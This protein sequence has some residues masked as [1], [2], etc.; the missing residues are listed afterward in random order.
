MIYVDL[1]STIQH[2]CLQYLA[3]H[4][5][6]CFFA[7]L[8]QQGINTLPDLIIFLF[9]CWAGGGFFSFVGRLAMP[10]GCLRASSNP[11]LCLEL[12]VHLDW[13]F[14]SLFG[15]PTL[16]VRTNEHCPHHGVYRIKELNIR[17]NKAEVKI[18]K[19][20]TKKKAYQYHKGA[21]S[22]QGWA[23]SDTKE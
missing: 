16:F 12:A 23:Y 3:Y 20:N 11:P 13:V 15:F 1:P 6:F 22:L 17:W 14:L 8:L 10:E 18:T 2:V 7:F 9:F 4:R 19:L 5:L 21:L